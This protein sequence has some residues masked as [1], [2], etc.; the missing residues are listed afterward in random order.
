[1][2]R[3]PQT[4]ERVLGLS[5]ADQCIAI[6]TEGSSANVRWANNTT[7][8]NGSGTGQSLSI[9]SVIDG[10]VGQISRNYFPDD[11]LPSLVRESEAACAGKPKA[12][13]VMPLPQGDG[14]PDDWDE[15]PQPTDIAVFDR[16]APDLAQLF[17]QA[18]ASDVALFGYAEHGAGTV[19]LAT[20]AG[21]RRRYRRPSGDLEITAK[22]PDYQRSAWIG[23]T[24]NTF[25]DVDLAHMYR[26]LEKKLE[27][28]R[29]RIDLPAGRYQVILEP[30]ATAD[31]LLYMYISMTARDADEGRT[32]FAKA[33]GGNRV[34]EHLFPDGVTIYSDPM[35]PDFEV[36]PFAVAGGSSSFQSIFDNGLDVGRTEWVK[37][38]ALNR[39]ITPRYW[40]AKSG[41]AQASFVPNL[42][43][44]S[45]GADLEGMI[46]RTERAVL[47]TCLWYIRAVDPQTLLLTGLTRDGVFLVEGG[48]VKGAVPNF[49]F[50]MSP[51]DMLKQAT[52]IGRA[53]PTLPREFG[54]ALT[55]MPPL[56]VEGWNMSSV[57]DAT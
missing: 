51:V 13:D 4:L 11:L 15:P 49:R 36:T 45:D 44:P 54:L 3:I 9:V 12:Q 46:A 48:E 43:F 34:G 33:G 31:M 38:G 22:S 5:K 7:T 29:K 18:S 57:S 50:N 40:A 25:Q 35:E 32:V 8:T 14:Y 42:V 21:I 30:S 26:R 24:T 20:S 52:E 23:R 17:K 47:V 6:G 1:M 56:R 53:E 16:L 55:K 39:L 27:W 28:S 19:Y 41:A 37:D 10:A 2:S